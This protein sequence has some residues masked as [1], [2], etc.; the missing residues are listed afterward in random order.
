MLDEIP[1]SASCRVVTA[2]TNNVDA[3]LVD[4]GGDPGRHATTSISRVGIDDDE[5]LLLGEELQGLLFGGLFE[6]QDYRDE[7][8]SL[9]RWDFG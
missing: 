2:G 7:F 5:H 8:G 6:R 9:G 4:V 1:V 3:I